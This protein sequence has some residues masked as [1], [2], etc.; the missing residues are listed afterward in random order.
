MN[1]ILLIT[2]VVFCSLQSVAAKEY[3]KRT[4]YAIKKQVLYPWQQGRRGM[5]KLISLLCIVM[6]ATVAYGAA[7]P[8]VDMADPKAEAIFDVSALG[9]MQGFE[10]G[11]FRADE[12]VTRAQF[13][14]IAVAAMGI[15]NAALTNT[16]F[17]DVTS[18]HWASGFIKFASDSK[19]INGIGGG[20]FAPEE[21]VTLQEAAKIIVCVLGRSIQAEAKGGY[22]SGYIAV[23]SELSLFD[24]IALF[25]NDAMT[26][27]DVAV[28][29][30]NAL[31]CHMMEST[32]SS[33]ESYVVTDRTLR[34]NLERYDDCKKVEGIV[35]AT[36]Y[37]SLSGV[38][39]L[40]GNYVTLDGVTYKATEDFSSLLGYRVIAYI[41]QEGTDQII[42]MQKY[43]NEEITIDA[44]GIGDI[45]ANT[46]KWYA[47]E[48]EDKEKKYNISG[49]EIIYNGKHSDKLPTIYNGTYKLVDNDANNHAD[50]LFVTEYESFI[51]DRVAANTVYFKNKASFRGK[52]AFKFITNDDDYTYEIYDF[53]GNAIE[54]SD[55]KADMSV[56]I[57]ASEDEK[58]VTIY[59]SDK[60]L[61]GSV[62]ALSGNEAFV[63]IDGESY[64]AAKNSAGSVILDVKLGDSADFALDI[65]GRIIDVIGDISDSEEYA[66]VI[67]AGSG[68]SLDLTQKIKVLKSGSREKI[69]EIVA[70]TEIIT[71]EYANS[72]TQVLE[73]ASK[74][75][76]DGT[77]LSS[78]ELNANDYVGMV[79]GYTLNNENKIKKFKSYSFSADKTIYAFNGKLQS[80]GGYSSREAFFAD[81]STAIFCV[82]EVADSE[83][84]WFELVTLAH[85]GTYDVKPIAIDPDTQKAKAAVIISKMDADSPTP[86]ESDKDVS[87]V[88]SVSGSLV[89]GE[90]AYKIT[91]LTDD[92]IEE[93]YTKGSGTAHETALALKKGDLIKYSLDSQNRVSTI[94]LLAS[95][96]GLDRFY[97][98]NENSPNETAY[99]ICYSIEVNKLSQLRNEMV[100]EISICFSDDGSG[101]IVEYDIPREEGPMVYKYNRRNGDV[102]VATTD[103]I[104]SYEEVGSNA[105]EVFVVVRNNSVQALVIIEK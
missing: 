94:K 60:K 57:C 80:F 81:E 105:T 69:T 10:D 64:E 40:D 56:T 43:G 74:V 5:K 23:A 62:T 18:D 20:L 86:I 104:T 68:S 29:L 22:P 53:D 41:S 49:A 4:M 34:M 89:D 31:D 14:K 71:Y 38:S 9:I 87:I 55:I 2:I 15:D 24:E 46:V 91:M 13:A 93:V 47:D 61:S 28:L 77:N 72:E 33:D 25:S 42:A 63:E 96:Q 67:A 73:F 58:L 92:E 78:S 85:K 36:R 97:R 75:N 95:I 90:E 84:D 101:Q 7:F 45:D 19:L 103:E 48:K 83:D 65:Q 37:T 100:D 32:Y 98:A 27:G 51:S 12:P 70:D 54:I 79:I 99:A 52:T 39:N 102:S 21:K 11:S 76:A 82:P 26:R 17:S 30:F 35:T 16:V 88:W 6:T 59:A 66:Y 8:D 1:I 50:V 44:Q 3:S